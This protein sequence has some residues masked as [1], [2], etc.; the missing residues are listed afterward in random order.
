M[1]GRQFQCSIYVAAA[2]S[3]LTACTH[4]PSTDPS[5]AIPPHA[6]VGVQKKQLT[7]EFWIARESNAK[8]IV[9]DSS[10]IAEQNARLLTLDPS[11]H[12]LEKFPATLTAAAVRDW[13]GKLSQ[14]PDVHMFDAEGRRA[15]T[16]GLRR[17]DARH[18][19]RGGAGEPAH[20]LWAGR[21]TRRSAHLPLAAAWLPIRRRPGYRSLPG[22]R[23]FSGHAR[24]DCARKP[25]WRT[26]G[27]S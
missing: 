12:D 10:A 5:S 9:L 4:Q 18:G 17:I 2:L 1:K 7:P 14:Y 21:E 3:F 16:S 19:P 15:R 22:N 13:I 6:V 27:S 11:V 24:G 25:R 23:A 20:A 26:G 8:K